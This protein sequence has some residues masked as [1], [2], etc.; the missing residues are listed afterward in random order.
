MATI[1][2]LMDLSNGEPISFTVSGSD[3]VHLLIGRHD[4]G[5]ELCLDYESTRI[6]LDRCQ[7][8]FAEMDASYAREQAED[9][10][11]RSASSAP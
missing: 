1:S 5:V 7:T 9:Q 8:A 3:M 2:T 11:R 4:L 10:G 6:L